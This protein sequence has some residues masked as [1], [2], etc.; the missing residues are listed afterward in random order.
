MGNHA[1][2]WTSIVERLGL[3]SGLVPPLI[4]SV[5][6]GDLVQ[7]LTPILDRLD[8]QEERLLPLQQ[9]VDLLEK[10]FSPAQE[11]PVHRSGL[12]GRGSLRVPVEGAEQFP[13]YR[14]HKLKWAATILRVYG[15]GQKTKDDPL[16][17][18]GYVETAQGTVRVP[19]NIFD[20]G[21]PV[22]GQDK[23]VIY[24]DGYMSWEP[25]DSFEAGHTRIEP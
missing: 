17:P 24:E 19:A 2:K 8:A 14:S 18:S 3:R 21:F 13:L 4:N 5:S 16:G 20:R 11:S 7:L 22:R 15:I 9:Q 1:T 10:R 6:Y 12:D 23:L 25:K